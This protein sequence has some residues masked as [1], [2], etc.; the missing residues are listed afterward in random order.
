M[1]IGDFDTFLFC[2]E[3]DLVIIKGL[4]VHEMKLLRFNETMSYLKCFCL[5]LLEYMMYDVFCEIKQVHIAEE[6][7]PQLP[8]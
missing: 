3:L 8:S 4:C 5:R 1:D 7:L 6:T 2:F